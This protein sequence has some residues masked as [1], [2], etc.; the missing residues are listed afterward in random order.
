MPKFGGENEVA[1]GGEELYVMRAEHD[2]SDRGHVP[3]GLSKNKARGGVSREH[4]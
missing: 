2:R 1:D 3:T 4:I